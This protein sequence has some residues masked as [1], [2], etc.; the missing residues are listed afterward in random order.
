MAGDRKAQTLMQ[1]RA[2]NALKRVKELENET[3]KARRNNDYA[4]TVSGF[5]AM[6]IANGLG[7]AL[8]TLLAS[9]KEHE[10]K[11]YEHL[12][13]WLCEGFD[14]APYHEDTNLITSIL[15]HDRASYIR[16]Q[17]EALEWLS[18]LK[19]FSVAYLKLE[20]EGADDG[21]HDHDTAVSK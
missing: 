9:G 20:Q 8:A 14:K 10:K 11:L 3:G 12:Q 17:V 2:G 16:A 4:Q 21:A 19:K 7:Q 6:I 13:A 15:E 1:L 18:W 5:P